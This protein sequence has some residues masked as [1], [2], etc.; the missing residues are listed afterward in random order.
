MRVLLLTHGTRGDVQPFV[1]LAKALHSAGH[2]PVLG[3]PAALAPLAAEH[4][5]RFT[6]LDDGPNRMLEDPE[7]LDP[8]L[9]SNKHNRAREVAGMLRVMREAKPAM[10]RVLADMASA[11]EGGADL[12]VHQANQPA[13]HIAEHLGVPAVPVGLQPVWVPTRAF[14]NPVLPVRVPAALN[15]ATYRLNHLALRTFAPVIDTW[16]RDTLGLARR[17]HQHDTLRRPDGTPATLLHAFSQHVVPP[18][19]DYPTWVHTTGY[20]F[21]DSSAEWTPPHELAEF[22]QAGKPPVFIGF[23]SMPN[24]AP[25]QTGQLLVRAVR[26]AGVRAVIAAGPTNIQLD[27]RCEDVLLIDQVPHDWIFPRVAAVVHAGGAGTTSEALRAN[28][29]QVLCPSHVEQRFWAQRMHA[30]HVACEPLPMHRLDANRLTDAI[31]HAVTDQTL[32]RRAQQ[33]APRIRTENGLAR[34]ITLLETQRAQ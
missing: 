3:A 8:V 2:E 11:A 25:E 19:R 34:A 15:R 14:P 24:T 21:L 12:V 26:N 28:R 7:R 33:L 17:R 23:G 13:H 1:A 27:H 31:L 18:P 20:W 29:P 6:P 4:G 5:V 30:L 32:T 22:L 10:V 9:G 16:R